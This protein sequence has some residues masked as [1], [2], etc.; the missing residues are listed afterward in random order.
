MPDHLHR[1]PT[2]RASMALFAVLVLAVVC[3][4]G[5]PADSA[6]AAM[7]VTSSEPDGLLVLRAASAAR[8][9]FERRPAGTV[10]NP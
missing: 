1:A 2:L 6:A 9:L 4:Q 7:P 5:R 8:A 3:N 10:S